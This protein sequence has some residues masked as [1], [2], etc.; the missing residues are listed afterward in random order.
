MWPTSSHSRVQ[1]ARRSARKNSGCGRPTPAACEVGSALMP[2]SPARPGAGAQL[3]R[4]RRGERRGAGRGR[5]A[6]AE[7]RLAAPLVDAGGQPARRRATVDARRDRAVR[8]ALGDQVVDLLDPAPVRVSTSAR[9]PRCGP[10]TATSRSRPPSWCGSPGRRRPRWR[11]ASRPARG[12]C[13]IGLQLGLGD[14]VGQVVGVARMPARSRRRGRGSSS[15][16]A[17]SR[18]R[19]RGR[20]RPR[21][22]RAAPALGDHPAGGV[23]DGCL[24]SEAGSVIMTYPD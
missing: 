7:Q 9:A 10:R 20:R 6:H 5:R 18:R 12:R 4:G 15:A 24:R 23:E 11:T 16:R 2:P 8:D 21:A 14:G 17:P 19:L 22:R 3:A 13:R 1:I